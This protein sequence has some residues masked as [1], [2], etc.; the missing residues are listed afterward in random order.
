MSLLQPCF[1]F[2]VLWPVVLLF[3]GKSPDLQK[4]YQ[5]PLYSSGNSSNQITSAWSLSPPVP[6]LVTLVTPKGAGLMLH[7]Q[8]LPSCLLWDS[9]LLGCSKVQ[10]VDLPKPGCGIKAKWQLSA[11]SQTPNS[12]PNLTLTRPPA[13][14]RS[15]AVAAEQHLIVW[16]VRM[17]RQS[18]R[19]FWGHGIYRIAA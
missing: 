12:Q 17:E 13:C 8:K 11:K 1:P 18:S 7:C 9:I 15:P 3:P 6:V 4:N 16:H 19:A 2:S 10:E 5:K 14:S